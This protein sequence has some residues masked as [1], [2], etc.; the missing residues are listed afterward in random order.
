MEENNFPAKKPSRDISVQSSI[1]IGSILIAISIFSGAYMLTKGG[2]GNGSAQATD[3]LTVKDRDGQPTIGN[4]KAPVTMY[5]FGDFQCPFCKRFYQESF[6]E[7]KA[8]YIDTGKVKVVFRHFP[9]T[10]IHVNA[11]ISSEAAECA[12]RQGKFEDYYNILYT[13]GQGDGGGLDSSSLKKYAIDLGLNTSV[14]NQCLDNHQTKS[15]IEADQA[16]GTSLGV[17]G[18]PAFFINGQLTLG[19]QP[20]SVIEQAIESALNK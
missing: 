12:N 18:T 14:F 6:A 9:L 10:N 11:E 8:K 19:A 1:L 2:F 20:T 15:V 3:K 17:T 16:L 4:T 7:L 5:E 13:K